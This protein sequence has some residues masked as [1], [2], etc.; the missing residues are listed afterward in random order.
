MEINSGMEESKFGLTI[1]DAPYIIKEIESL[2]NIRVRGLMTIPP[3]V[4]NGEENRE[5]FREMKNLF[6]EL[7]KG[8]EHF[9]TLSMGMSG[10]YE[11][12]VEE[13]ATIVRVGTKIFGERNY[14]K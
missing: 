9:D 5:N 8:R 12:A 14:N 10:D 1:K 7:K 3:L 11:V 6:D 13:G 2:P 4:E